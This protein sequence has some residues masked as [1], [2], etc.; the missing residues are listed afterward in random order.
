MTKD[1]LK[2]EIKRGLEAGGSV[3]A[4]VLLLEDRFGRLDPLNL[5]EAV[6][7]I[8]VESRDKE[9]RGLEL[10]Y[11]SALADVVRY[12]KAE[13]AQL[14]NEWHRKSRPSSRRGNR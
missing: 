3:T 14:E 5:A 12:M 6:Y 2:E 9:V 11:E 8:G 4:V 10:K 7:E 13:K 1:E